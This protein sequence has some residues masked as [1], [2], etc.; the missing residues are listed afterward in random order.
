M[1]EESWKVVDKISGR[2][3]NT[4]T[5]DF[6]IDEEP[7]I[8]PP[9]KDILPVPHLLSVIMATLILIYTIIIGRKHRKK[10]KVILKGR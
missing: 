2:L 3:T 7:D 9:D 8:I 10:D 6:D 1:E 5:G 4:T